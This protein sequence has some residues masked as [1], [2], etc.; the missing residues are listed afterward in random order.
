MARQHKAL[1]GGVIVFCII[2]LF[3]PAVHSQNIVIKKRT[4]VLSG[5]VGLPGVTMQGLPG[6]P[7]TDEN[8]VY[9]TEVEYGW[10]GTVTPVKVGYVFE[11]KQKVYQRVKTNMTDESYSANPQYPKW[12][13]EVWYEVWI[14]W[15]AFGDG[16]PGAVYITELH[17]SPNK[18]SAKKLPL[19]PGECP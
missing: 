6:A 2:F 9:S 14:K 17:A 12:I 11:P 4:F 16:G 19:V 8:G 13:F 18:T 15:S 10:S 7:M 3:A 5:A 1:S